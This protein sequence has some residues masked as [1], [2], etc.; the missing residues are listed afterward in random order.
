M[1]LDDQDG[2]EVGGREKVKEGGKDSLQDP[3]QTV[4]APHL[5]HHLPLH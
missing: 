1:E 5:L 2:G 4:S 3:P